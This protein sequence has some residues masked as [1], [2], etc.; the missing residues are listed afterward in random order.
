MERG[1]G[2]EVL[3]KMEEFK[4]I[5]KIFFLVVVRVFSII[6]E[7][8]DFFSFFVFVCEIIFGC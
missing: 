2:Y 1:I 5:Y 7:R 6:V 3:M 4:F 8:A